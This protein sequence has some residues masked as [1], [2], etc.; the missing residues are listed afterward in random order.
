[1]SPAPPLLPSH[2]VY[3]RCLISM[4]SCVRVGSGSY[5]QVRYGIFRLIFQGHQGPAGMKGERGAVGSKVSI[6][7]ADHLGLQRR[8]D[9]S[10]EA[11][12]Y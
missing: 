11:S 6:F 5:F 2:L 4:L 10:P 9:K 3:L 8:G 12:L 7:S 1:M